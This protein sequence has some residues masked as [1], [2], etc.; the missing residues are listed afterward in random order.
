VMIHALNPY[1]FAWSRRVDAANRD[2]NRNFILADELFEGVPELYAK[3]NELL[4][5]K[6]PPRP[7]EFFFH[8]ILWCI[9]RYGFK[10]LQA[11]IASGQ[12]EYPAGLFFGGHEAAQ[13]SHLLSERLAGWLAGSRRVV[14]IDLHTGLGPYAEPLL[15]MDS[16]LS[17]Q[18]RREF[19]AWFG[20]QG[21]RDV[22]A[23][24]GFYQ[25]KGSFGRWCRAHCGVDDYVYACADFGTYS[26]IRVLKTLRAENRCYYWAAPESQQTKQAKQEL[27]EVFCPQSQAWR[28][29][30]LANAGELTRNAIEGLLHSPST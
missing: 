18:H 22:D 15:L 4:N 24:D 12:Y 8:Q 29:K 7:Y 9:T 10:A 19:V 25:A 23:N 13:L 11:A 21:F 1:G 3:L 6:R 20:P 14:H 27:K 2:L 28:R 5:P 16:K 30:S 26:P 17:E